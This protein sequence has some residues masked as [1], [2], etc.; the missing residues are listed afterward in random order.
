M[1]IPVAVPLADFLNRIYLVEG[2][3]LM[4]L[5]S[6]N[7]HLYPLTDDLVVNVSLTERTPAH[8]E[9]YKWFRDQTK[10]VPSCVKQMSKKKQIK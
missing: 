7:K 8:L 6:D 3:D 2:E 10:P 4:V 1:A 9:F 5:L